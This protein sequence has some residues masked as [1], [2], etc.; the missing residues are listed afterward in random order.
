[1]TP[2][3][4]MVSTPE[5]SAGPC[6]TGSAVSPVQIRTLE[7]P[8]A[9]SQTRPGGAAARVRA[10]GASATISGTSTAARTAK[11]LVRRVQHEYGVIQFPPVRVASFNLLLFVRRRAALV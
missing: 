3:H 9:I 8:G 11:R 10:P 4:T 2:S 7:S 1:M 6:R 5:K